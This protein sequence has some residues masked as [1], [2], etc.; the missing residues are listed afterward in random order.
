[1]LVSWVTYVCSYII[2]Y[3]IDLIMLYLIIFL[4]FIWTGEIN[5]WVICSQWQTAHAGLPNT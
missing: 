5:H 2:G 1:M 3:V 4:S